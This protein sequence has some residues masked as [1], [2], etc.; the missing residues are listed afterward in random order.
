[1]KT[2][3]KRNLCIISTVLMAIAYLLVHATVWLTRSDI[4]P[5][6]IF[7]DSGNWGLLLVLVP[8]VFAIWSIFWEPKKHKKWYIVVAALNIIPI[9]LIIVSF[10]TPKVIGA[11]EL[12]RLWRYIPAI[13]LYFAVAVIYLVLAFTKNIETPKEKE[14]I[15]Y[16]E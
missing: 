3:V 1:M 4:D 7:L 5:P 8:T 15:P 12:K 10:T 2:T 11:E 14:P 13:I 16:S 9:I 6:L